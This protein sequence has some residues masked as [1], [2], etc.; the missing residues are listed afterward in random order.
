MWLLWSLITGLLPRWVRYVRFFRGI[1]FTEVVLNMYQG[2]LVTKATG[3]AVNL[4]KFKLPS[5]SVVITTWS[6]RIKENERGRYN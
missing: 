4:D 5:F 3:F 1:N 2:G 6:P